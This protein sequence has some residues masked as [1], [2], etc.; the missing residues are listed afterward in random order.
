[1]EER[2]FF[3]LLDRCVE[4]AGLEFL[5][6]DRR[7]QVGARQVAPP[8]VVVRVHRP[9]FF[10][11]VL[12][13]GNLG[14]AEAFMERDFELEQGSLT[15]LLNVLI[16]NRLDQRLSGRLSFASAARLL[17][18]RLSNRLRGARGNIAHHYD[19]DDDTL[20]EAFLDPRMVYS[21]GYVK[22]PE[23]D[24]EQF[25]LDKLRR[26]CDK[27]RLAPGERLVDIGCGYGGLLIFA[28]QEYGVTGKGITLGRRHCERAKANVAAAGLSDRIEIE[29]LPYQQLTGRFD[30]V[31]SLGMME[32]LRRSEYRRFTA[33]VSRV[34]SERGMGLFHYIGCT[35]P[36]NDHDP[37][38]QRYILPDSSQPKLSE[39]VA[40]LE[41]HDLAVLDVEN[42]IRHYGYTLE[43]WTRSFLANRSRLD[44]TRFDDRFQRMWQYYL[45]CAAAAA[46]ASAAGLF[47]IVFARNYPPPMP[48]QRV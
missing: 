39:F 18:I 4:D 17:W 5:I 25:Q 11:R 21:C 10:R 1:M 38:I 42:L 16:R 23:A 37:F 43:G 24:V 7:V 30:K 6:G 35:G 8:A 19:H 34:L 12:A 14:M 13:E 2:L 41:N 22:D 29:L 46:F 20:F 32:H 44:P 36:S 47:Q 26:V 28:A 3:E 27:L 33:V 15:E 40:Q 9:R 48:L 31:V 45:E